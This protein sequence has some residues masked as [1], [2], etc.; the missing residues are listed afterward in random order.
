[1]CLDTFKY[2]YWKTIKKFCSQH[3]AVFFFFTHYTQKVCYVLGPCIDFA[4]YGGNVIVYLLLSMTDEACFTYTQ[5]YM[6][7]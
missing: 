7:S 1:M 3:F 6:F 5:V 4:L 2:I